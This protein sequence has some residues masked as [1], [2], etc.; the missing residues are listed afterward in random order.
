LDN[1]YTQPDDHSVI[2][3]T[4]RGFGGINGIIIDAV[5]VFCVNHAT[6]A[7][8]IPMTRIRV[9]ATEDSPHGWF[10]RGTILDA[11]LADE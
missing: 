5:K 11:Y 2:G 4:H 6:G 3:Q 8:D 7:Q 1:K 10:K 9:Q